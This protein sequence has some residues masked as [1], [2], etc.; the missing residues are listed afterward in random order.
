MAA[1]T[2]VLFSYRRCPYAIR[3]RLALAYA[4]VHVHTHEVSLRDKPAPMLAVS[5]KGTVPVLVL[6]SGQVLE[7]SLDIMRWALQQHDPDDWLYADAHNPS[8]THAQQQAERWLMRNDGAF[9]R[10]LDAYKY[11]ERHPSQSQSAHRADA[12]QAL[13]EPLEQQLSSSAYVL[14]ARVSYVD[15]ALVPFVR[16]FVA[17]DRQWFDEEGARLFPH[18]ARWLQGWLSTN[19][20]EAVMAKPAQPSIY[21]F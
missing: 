20:F 12:L 4:Q 15:A 6:P 18:V 7:Q 9:K 21:G 3:A 10:A 5:P 13:I 11:P 8:P 17:V 19:L 14:G 1:A 16:Q 2:P